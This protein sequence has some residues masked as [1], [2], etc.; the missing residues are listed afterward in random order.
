MDASTKLPRERSLMKDNIK[1]LSM[2]SLYHLFNDG[3]I[4]LVPLLFP[5][6]R[7]L[8]NL[9]YSQIGFIT[10]TGLAISLVFQFLIGS[11]SDKKNFRTLL[12]IGIG[13]LVITLL[14]FP[15]IQG[16][17]SLF[18]LFIFLRFSASFFHPIGIGLIS[19][20]FKKDRLD[21]AMGTQSAFGDLG[22]F[23]AIASTLFIAE[24]FGWSYPFYIWAVLG[25]ISILISILLTAKI[26]KLHLKR[27]TSS[28][29]TSFSEQIKEYKEIISNLR[30]YAPMLIISGATWGATITY[31]PLY[32]DEKT[33]L[34]LSLI[35]LIVSVWIGTGTIASFFYGKMHAKIG[36]KKIITLCY[37]TIA[38]MNLVLIVNPLIWI[39][40]LIV[41]LL[42]VATFLTFPI[43]FSYISENTHESNEAKTFGFIFTLQLGGG[44]ILL[45]ISGFLSDVYGI[46][47]P[48]LFLSIASVVATFS[49]FLKNNSLNKNA[50]NN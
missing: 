41:S 19:R 22:V 7:T 6:F 8:F 29:Q 26:P 30:Y 24:S 45:Y 20:R 25:V 5:I 23:I 46:W 4:S 43:L 12:T 42:G 2:V 36:R 44:T 15:T 37:L 39:I 16:F 49:I 21:W 32:L 40:P 17:L 38:I 34:S 28:D 27:E 48:F 9:S 47:I 14:L 10:G 35:G 13:L 33:A 3:V 31:L 11:S 18:I 50:V 1:I